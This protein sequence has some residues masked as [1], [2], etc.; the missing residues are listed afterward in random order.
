[1]IGDFKLKGFRINVSSTLYLP[2]EDL[3]GQTNSTNQAENGV[4]PKR[5]GIRL[6]ISFKNKSWLSALVA[7]AEKEDSTG[8]R[9]I[10]DIVDKTA[11]A[12]NIRQVKFTDNFQVREDE[13]MQSWSVNFV[14]TEHRSIAEK[15]Q[16][17]RVNAQQK[18]TGG[19]TT[20]ST[21]VPYKEQETDD[22]TPVTMSVDKGKKDELTEFEKVLKKIDDALGPDE[23]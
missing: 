19:T 10:H 9:K 1:M 7:I 13:K 20:D 11:E 6:Q 12:M 22:T 8:R 2:V 18:K 23:T 4:K 17:R 16:Q 14:L 15:Q 5:L 21:P 3:S